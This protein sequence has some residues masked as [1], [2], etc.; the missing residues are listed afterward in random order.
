MTMQARSLDSTVSLFVYRMMGAATLDAAMYE[1]IEG[2]TRVTSQAAAAVLLSSFA[3]GIGAGGLYGLRLSVFLG[4]VV[5]ALVMWLAWAML[6]YQIGSRLLPEPATRTT[7]GELLRTTGFAAA[8]GVLQ[9]FA[10]FPGMLIPVFVGTWIW[11]LAA[12]VV[13]VRHALDYESNARAILVCLVAVGLSV[14]IALGF[15]VAFGPAVG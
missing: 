3:A 10:V 8:P 1:G 14:A 9:A 2:D 13:G 6:V 5:L 4:T 7:F 12:M 11:M 15:G